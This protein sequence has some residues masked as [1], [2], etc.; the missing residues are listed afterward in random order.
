ARWRAFHVSKQL[1]SAA[2]ARLG[3]DVLYV[4]PP[5]SPF[6]LRHRDR[7]IDLSRKPLHPRANLEV[8]TPLVLPGQNGRVGQRLNGRILLRGVARRAARPDIVV[9]F[10][11]EARAVFERLRGRRVYY[12]TDSFEDLPGESRVRLR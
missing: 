2:L 10:A 5:L 12:C 3:H 11:L 8:W 4:D 7:L 9:S 1:V 6:S